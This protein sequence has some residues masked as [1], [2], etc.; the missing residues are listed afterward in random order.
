LSAVGL[1]E[2]IADDVAGYEEKA[3]ALARNSAERRRLRDHLAGPGR[4]SA[5]FDTARTTKALETAYLQMADQYR[6][7]VREPFRVHPID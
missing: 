2:L 7:R 1:P 6:R 4:E 3:I 5:L